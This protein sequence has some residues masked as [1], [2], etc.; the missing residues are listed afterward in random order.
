[1]STR[2]TCA[3][4]LLCVVQ[5]CERFAFFAMLP[6][7]VLYLHHRH[8]FSEPSAML[9]FGVFHALSYVGGLPAG[10]LTDRKLGPLI[11]IVSGCGTVDAGLQ[12]AC[13]GFRGPLFWPALALIVIGHSFFKPSMSTLFS[14]LFASADLRRDRGFLWQHPAANIGAMVGP[15]CGEW[16][17]AGHRWDRLFFWPRWRCSS[18]PSPS[19]RRRT[20]FAESATQ[21]PVDAA[22]ASIS[23]PDRSSALG[24]RV[25]A[26]RPVSR[27]LADRAAVG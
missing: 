4:V 11:A 3:L 20:T 15:L 24:C 14:A 27:V 9:L 6:L 12:R 23:A 2:P 13:P 8:G 21:Q 10:I 18:A 17:S 5:G 22:M 19:D 26:V 16:A 1:M 25:V 7:F